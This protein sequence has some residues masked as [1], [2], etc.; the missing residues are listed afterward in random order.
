[1]TAPG[2]CGGQLKMG[3]S[4]LRG[5][6]TCPSSWFS[7]QK[8]SSS[9]SVAFWSGTTRAC[10]RFCCEQH[11]FGF[12]K[13]DR[14]QNLWKDEKNGWAW[15]LVL[16][17]TLSW[18]IFGFSG[19][20]VDFIQPT[21]RR[22]LLKLLHTFRTHTSGKMT[23]KHNNKPHPQLP[24]WQIYPYIYKYINDDLRRTE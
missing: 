1:M 7:A 5:F 14:R 3:V 13:C 19:S 8:P 17:G 23:K 15:K 18:L 20:R 12:Y 21:V 2:T 6:F 22:D 16:Q 11:F 10:V 9:S 4:F 24:V